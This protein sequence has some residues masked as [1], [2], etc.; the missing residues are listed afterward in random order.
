M[1]PTAGLKTAATGLMSAV[2]HKTVADWEKNRPV[3][4]PTL[5]RCD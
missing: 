3:F 5:K 1:K 2:K 4:M